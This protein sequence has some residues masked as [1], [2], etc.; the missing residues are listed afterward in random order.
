MYLIFVLFGIRH[1][2]HECFERRRV[3]LHSPVL[4]R[5][6]EVAVLGTT[7]YALSVVLPISNYF[8]L[9]FRF[10]CTNY[11]RHRSR[12]DYGVILKCGTAGDVLLYLLLTVGAKPA[13]ERMCVFIIIPKLY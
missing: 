9:L 13:S 11:S 5:D 7:R 8:S 2:L 10:T 4:A 3:L 12:L 1:L 6:F